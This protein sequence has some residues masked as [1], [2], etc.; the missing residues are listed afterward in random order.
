VYVITAPGLNVTARPTL[1]GVMFKS[2]GTTALIPVALKDVVIGVA[3][4]SS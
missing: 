3:I 1:I 4:V 2:N